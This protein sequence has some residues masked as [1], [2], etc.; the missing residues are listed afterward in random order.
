[1]PAGS[2]ALRKSRSLTTTVDAVAGAVAHFHRA[3]MMD[4]DQGS[5]A[6]K[7]AEIEDFLQGFNQPTPCGSMRSGWR[8][9]S[10]A[11]AATTGRG[12]IGYSRQTAPAVQMATI[13]ISS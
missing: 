4:F 8:Q 11:G 3:M 6:M 2:E 13:E 7:D 10:T 12:P 9:A 1:V 5:K